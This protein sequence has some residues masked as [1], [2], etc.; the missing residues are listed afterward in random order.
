V[1]N[2]FCQTYDQNSGI[3]LSCY[4]GYYVSGTVC[5]VASPICQTINSNGAC[6]S[7][8]A[9]Y[10][11]WGNTC[12]SQN[13]LNPYCSSFVGATCVNCYYGYYLGTGICIV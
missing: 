13:T 3:C 9:G 1:A 8:Y 12:I 4:A 2:P 6:T 10:I 5:L 11:L 7:C